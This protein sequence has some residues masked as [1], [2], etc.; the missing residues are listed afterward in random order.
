MTTPLYSANAD[1][2]YP[3]SDLHTTAIPNDILLDLSMMLPHAYKVGAVV[4]SPVL[5]AIHTGPGFAFVSFDRIDG[6]PV[7]YAM[8]EDPVPGYIYELTMEEGTG[9]VVF[10]PG[11]KTTY[12]S[13]FVSVALDDNCLLYVPETEPVFQLSL[14]GQHQT[15]TGVM[16]LVSA[17]PWL[18]LQLR[19]AGD[20]TII[21][22]LRTT[23]L[24]EED[25]LDLL[26]DSP[27]LGADTRVFTVGGVVPVDGA[28]TLVLDEDAAFADC[29]PHPAELPPRD[30]LRDEPSPLPLDE[31]T[32]TTAATPF[33]CIEDQDPLPVGEAADEDVTYWGGQRLEIVPVIQK[34]QTVASGL[35]IMKGAGA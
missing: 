33:P 21:D 32:G 9:W 20:I 7:G 6:E 3:L 19:E 2:K 24:T 34:G 10:G 14:N 18:E 12:N 35:V 15:L 30:L 31:F 1:I 27:E 11:V 22:I 5:T 13:G 23:A 29:D 26:A 8:V 25:R 4:Q 17:S 28:I 16:N